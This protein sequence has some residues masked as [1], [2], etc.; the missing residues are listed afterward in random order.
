MDTQ[1]ATYLERL[2]HH[3]V[4]V[5]G[6]VGKHV[7]LLPNDLHG[8]GRPQGGAAQS[9]GRMDGWMDFFVWEGDLF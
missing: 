7:R 9:D 2:H 4:E 6:H 1:T 3:V 5:G 8:R